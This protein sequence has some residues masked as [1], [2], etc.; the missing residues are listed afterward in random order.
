MAEQRDSQLLCI[1]GFTASLFVTVLVADEANDGDTFIF[2]LVL[3][4]VTDTTQF[5]AITNCCPQHL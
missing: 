1:P 2:T 5:S 3:I 4:E